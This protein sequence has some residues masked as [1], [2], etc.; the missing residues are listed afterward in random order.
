MFNVGEKEE[1]EDE[2]RTGRDADVISCHRDDDDEDKT[3][4]KEGRKDKNKKYIM[5]MNRYER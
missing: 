3:C 1:E 4:R 2:V 5:I